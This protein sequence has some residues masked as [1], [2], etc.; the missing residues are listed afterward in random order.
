MPELMDLPREIRDIIY[1]QALSSNQILIAKSE[2][3]GYLDNR[4]IGSAYQ[5]EV[6]WYMYEDSEVSFDSAGDYE[7]WYDDYIEA[8][9]KLHAIDFRYSHPALALL[10]VSKTINTEATAIFYGINTFR[11]SDPEVYGVSGSVL[12]KHAAALRN[13]VLQLSGTWGPDCVFPHVVPCFTEPGDLQRMWDTQ[14]D[15]L[16]HMVNL[17]FLELDVRSL[18]ISVTEWS[19]IIFEVAVEAVKRFLLAAV[20]PMVRQK[21]GVRGQ[22][23]WIT[24]TKTWLQMYGLHK[25]GDAWKDLGIN[26]EADGSK[27]PPPA[28]EGPIPNPISYHLDT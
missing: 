28:I 22:G 9:S 16:K 12:L 6:F 20:S 18:T 2:V 3:K 27:Y 15:A 7:G 10:G 23:I 25:V 21:L 17:R 13:V 19:P 8:Q 1:A 5:Q 4:K 14:L 26:F 11:L 24:N